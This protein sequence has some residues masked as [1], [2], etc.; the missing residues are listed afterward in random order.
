MPERLALKHK[1]GRLKEIIEDLELGKCL[2]TSTYTTTVLSQY[3]SCLLGFRSLRG[4]AR[5]CL[6][7]FGH[8]VSIVP[9][10]ASLRSSA[11]DQLLVPK[12]K[13]KL[14]GNRSF[15]V[16][17]PIEWNRLPS[18]LH[19]CLISLSIFKKRLLGGIFRIDLLGGS[20]DIRFNSEGEIDLTLLLLEY[21]E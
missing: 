14:Y 4:L 10:R 20:R 6:L 16:S 17:G 19:D 8:S 1:Q 5:E 12:I 13:T 2:D 9:G 15:A 21:K 18:S 11:H 7:D 3:K